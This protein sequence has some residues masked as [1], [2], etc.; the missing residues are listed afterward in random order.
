MSR[1]GLTE[2]ATFTGIDGAVF[3]SLLT[4]VWQA[5]AGFVSL[6]LLAR[7]LSPKEQG[8]YYTFNSILALQI[9]FE[10]GFSYVLMQFVSHER[11]A[12]QWDQDR[13]LV[14]DITAITRVDSLIKLAAR[15]YACAAIGLVLLIIPAGI[16]FFNSKHSEIGGA[17]WL[18][19]W[20][21]L[22]L[23][24]AGSLMTTPFFAILEGLGLV[25]QV[26]MFRTLQEVICGLL[27]WIALYSRMGLYSACVYQ[28]ARFL[29]GSVWLTLYYRRFF[30][31]AFR[32][33]SEKLAVN[34]AAEIWPLQWKISL[35]W[36]SGYFGNQ[37]F[38]PA[39]FALKGPVI[40]GRLGM[41]LSLVSGLSSAT[42]AWM[43]TKA[44]RF[45]LLVAQK[46]Y[47]ELD[48]IFRHTLQ[49]CAFT[50]LVGACILLAGTIALQYRRLPLADRLLDPL[51]LTLL[52]IAVLASVLL[53]SEA[54]YLRSHKQE[55]FLAL[56]MVNGAAICASA[57]ICGHFWGVTGMLTAYC[58]IMLLGG[59]LWGTLTFFK[60]RRLWHDLLFQ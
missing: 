19:A 33:F 12:T 47:S 8:I 39:A 29:C 44:P 60:K 57:V 16:V 42:L 48:A 36:L 3:Y 15:W 23:F 55:P 24:S 27:L 30:T 28:G 18:G 46:K 17:S 54:I 22:A 5:A 1:L 2:F 51:D 9:F 13:M 53:S 49:R 11:V 6:L 14:G 32:S 35:S 37:V 31:K 25:K 40:A 45:G 50:S 26:A 43:T 52:L 7:F 59:V 21:V 56:S 10:L 34:W 58:I 20:I 4:K 41:S 38:I